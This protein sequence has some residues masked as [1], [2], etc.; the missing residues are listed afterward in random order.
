MPTTARFTNVYNFLGTDV[1]PGLIAHSLTGEHCPW[2][3]QAA[4]GEGGIGPSRLRDS[5]VDFQGF[6]TE[7]N[8]H[9]SHGWLRTTWPSVLQSQQSTFTRCRQVILNT[10]S[11]STCRSSQLGKDTDLDICL[12][13]L[14]FLGSVPSLQLPTGRWQSWVFPLVEERSGSGL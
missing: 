9:F 5:P 4:F 3:K 12:K 8:Q 6:L 7:K 13:L 14:T 11:P 2:D 10:I 1:H